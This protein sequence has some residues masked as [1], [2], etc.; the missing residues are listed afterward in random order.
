MRVQ[1]N[2]FAMNYQV[3]QEA[4]SAFA[5]GEEVILE[6]GNDHD[7][8]VLARTLK[9]PDLKREV[10]LGSS[11]PVR[12]VRADHDT[13]VLGTVL[14]GVVGMTA[15][16]AVDHLTQTNPVIGTLAKLALMTFGAFVGGEVMKDAEVQLTS[17]PE[18]GSLAFRRTSP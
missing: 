3:R 9:S 11:V 10:N 12:I 6:R 8:D 17:R 7:E 14:G 16:V 15:G 4:A 18:S 1:A 2:T 13:V 5:K